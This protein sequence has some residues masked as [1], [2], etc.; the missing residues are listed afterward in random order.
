MLTPPT[1]VFEADRLR[2]LRSLDILD[3]PPEE[4]FD[5]LTR[6]ARRLFDVPIALVSL[7]DADRQWFKSSQGLEATETGRDISFCGHTILSDE[8]FV[9]RDAADDRRFCDNPLVTHDPHIR[10]YAG[11]PIRTTNGRR[12]GTFCVI[13]RRP[14]ELDTEDRALLKDLAAMVEREI[15]QFELAT[16]DELTGLANRRGFKAVAG[17]ALSL[18][19]RTDVPAT[20]LLIDLDHFKQINDDLGHAE[21]DRALC[22]MGEVLNATYRECDVIARLGGDEF[23]VLLSGAGK[24]D[25]ERPLKAL[26]ANVCAR[27]EKVDDNF[28]LCYSIGAAHFDP[29]E[30]RAVDELL[31][32]ADAR[33][34]EHKRGRRLNQTAS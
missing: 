32:E 17:Q 5:R 8:V 20:L 9:V 12:I 2:S 14:R 24:E 28:R 11:C 4:S 7:V 21:G 19:Q 30:H 29:G 22:E 27:N 34:Y 26:E 23:C 13:D 10:F 16:V 1:P 31:R 15:T 25:I 18:C 33:M 6:M 3:T